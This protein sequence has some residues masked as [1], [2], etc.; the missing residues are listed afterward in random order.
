[1]TTIKY[2]ND[3]EQLHREGDLPAIEWANGDRHWW[4]NGKRHRDNG[5]PA[6]ENADGDKFWF[7]N[8]LVHRDNGL[9]AIEW[10]NGDRHWY[11]NG[12]RHR[13]DGLPASEQ[14]NGSK[15]WYVN[16]KRHRANGLPAIELPSGY[17]EWWVKGIQI[18]SPT[19]KHSDWIGQT[20]LITLETIETDSEVGKCD[21]CNALILFDALLEWLDGNK[22]CPHCRSEWTN[23]ICY[24]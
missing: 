5:L 14:M 11:V 19:S 4:I 8:G 10:A 9:P 22:T 21:V 1:M 16:G 24:V 7:R 18:S 2:R 6:I 3:K 20:C 15:H 12:K 13:N 17:K 23:L